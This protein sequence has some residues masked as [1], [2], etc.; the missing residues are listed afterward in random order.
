MSPIQLHLIRHGQGYHNLKE[1][2]TI[3]DPD[4]TPLGEQQSS[5]LSQLIPNIQAI[6]CIFA[7][8]MRRTLQTALLTFQTL[9]QS[10]PTLRII[11]LPELQETSSDPCDTGS[12]IAEL[13]KEY[14]GKPVDLSLLYEG[15]NDKSVGKFRPTTDLTEQ[16]AGEVRKIL[17]DKAQGNVAVV[18]HGG[19]LH[20]LTEDW[21]GSSSGSGTGWTNCEY[22][23]YVFDHSSSDA[24]ERAAIIE[25]NDSIQRRYAS[26]SYRPLTPAEQRELRVEA[27]KMW[28]ADGYIVLSESKESQRVIA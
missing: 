18:A 21:E 3:P 26:G 22:R 16:R 25:T 5:L 17:Q 20:Y 27:E 4:L 13:R 15:W 11:A 1:D 19:L 6:N 10:N 12:S 28:A 2:Y 24:I 14:E 7:S 23:T 9:F 8:P